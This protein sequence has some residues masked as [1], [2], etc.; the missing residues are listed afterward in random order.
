MDCVLGTASTNRAECTLVTT[1]D[2]VTFTITKNTKD[3]SFEEKM[4][5]LLSKDG[6]E[7]IAEGSG[8]Y[9]Y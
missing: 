6:I 4:Y 7:V 8:Y 9:E 2:A 3:P 5:E 1:G